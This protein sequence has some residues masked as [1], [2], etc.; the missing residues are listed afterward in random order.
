MERIAT[1]SQCLPPSDSCGRGDA[2]AKGHVKMGHTHFYGSEKKAKAMAEKLPI[3]GEALKET[4][5]ATTSEC[6]LDS[7]YPKAPFDSASSKIAHSCNSTSQ[8]ACEEDFLEVRRAS[9]YRSTKLQK[10]FQLGV[11]NEPK[12][13]KKVD[14]RQNLKRDKLL[15]GANCTQ[16]R[17]VA[18]KKADD[19]FV[20]NESSKKF[21]N[22][23]GKEKKE[24]EGV[25]RNMSNLPH[26]LQSRERGETFQERALHFGVLDWSLLEK[27]N[28]KQGGKGRRRSFHSPSGSDT[29]SSFSTLE[30]SS[31]SCRSEASS[32]TRRERSPP[33][34]LNS[35]LNSA[36]VST[37]NPQCLSQSSSP[38]KGQ[39]RHV[40]YVDGLRNDS[41]Q[42]STSYLQMKAD[43]ESLPNEYL[44]FKFL[45]GNIVVN[46]GSELG[47]IQSKSDPLE[48]EIPF[49]DLKA[50]EYFYPTGTGVDT[51]KED[52]RS[53]TEQAGFELPK[54]SWVSG[55]ATPRFFSAGEC[56][57]ETCSEVSQH[58]EDALPVSA[59]I[60]STH[61]GSLED[62][63]NIQFVDCY[64]ELPNSNS[65]GGDMQAV[66]PALL[67]ECSS[68]VHGSSLQKA[69][70][71]QN[72]LYLDDNRS[73]PQDNTQKRL[74]SKS[75]T[76]TVHDK[77]TSNLGIALHARSG[78]NDVLSH[79]S[80]PA[81]HNEPVQDNK[82]VDISLKPALACSDQL[83]PKTMVRE[84]LPVDVSRIHK[85]RRAKSFSVSGDQ[86][87]AINHVESTFMT[88]KSSSVRA[89]A[90]SCHSGISKDGCKVCRKV[91]VSP[92]R[93]WIDP[94]VK[95]RERHQM[96]LSFYSHLEGPVLHHEHDSNGV[97]NSR[98]GTR[99]DK[100]LKKSLTWGFP[101]AIH[102]ASRS[103][104][105]RSTSS[106]NQTFFASEIDNSSK[107]FLPVSRSTCISPEPRPE[108][109]SE[110]LSDS[111]S[112]TNNAC[113][114]TLAPPAHPPILQ[115]LLHFVYKN[116]LPYFTFSLNESEKVLA[117]KTWKID[118]FDRKD[119]DWMYTFHSGQNN[120]KKRNKTGWVNWGRKD[121]HT[122]DIVGK[123]KVSC[124]LCTKLNNSGSMEHL[125][126]T[127]FVLFDA[128]KGH[129]KESPAMQTDFAEK[130][131]IGPPQLAQSRDSSS[132]AHFSDSFSTT[133]S[134]S[135][136]S[137]TTEILIPR[138][139]ASP[140]HV[141]RKR[142]MHVLKYPFRQS[143]SES[144][145]S[146][147]MRSRSAGRNTSCQGTWSDS[148]IVDSDTCLSRGFWPH[149]ELAALVI[150]VPLEQR[151]SVK[152][153]PEEDTVSNETG[154]WG[155]RFL[156]KNGDDSRSESPVN[157]PPP[158]SVENSHSDYCKDSGTIGEYSNTSAL[159]SIQSSGRPSFANYSLE[160][161][162]TSLGCE[163]QRHSSVTVIVPSG[164]HSLPTTD[165]SGPSSL[166]ERWRSGGRCDCGGWDLG[167]TL[168]LLDNRN[169][170]RSGL[171]EG[172]NNAETYHASD[173]F[174]RGAKQSTPALSLAVVHDGLYLL[175][176]EAQLSA[177]QAFSIGV[178]M[179][180]S[181]EPFMSTKES[182]LQELCSSSLCAP[183][184]KQVR[185]LSQE[186]ST[187]QDDILTNVY[188]NHK[189]FSV[190][191]PPHSPFG[192]V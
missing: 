119:F 48:N 95:S 167:C 146:S 125:V 170:N 6:N 11:P 29:S 150:R 13:E 49:S 18:Q 182:N 2:R 75:L 188:R 22:H 147:P 47:E 123:M 113:S 45:E 175:S 100:S 128:N 72:H 162:D 34:S 166:I 76:F 104:S 131:P 99:A 58:S 51:E 158:E 134:T 7:S 133:S 25:I 4:P 106:E 103:S 108:L 43:S 157:L 50:P 67:D 114:G 132:N 181:R 88:S 120:N 184:A 116:G 152:G 94:I 161:L 42:M 105:A 160:S 17:E 46:Q 56:S 135:V 171:M 83:Q 176:F 28:R 74:L 66:D 117:A 148:D 144:R 155:L 19:Y 107:Q 112:E 78:S 149:L 180:H 16:K 151:E 59:V 139:L 32:F 38:A 64:D 61:A 121:N 177:L 92:L 89:D 86:D 122:P 118:K 191:D 130:S 12:G 141:D 186:I 90:C 91:S 136:P 30:S 138:S 54:E 84:G 187:P 63:V 68:P 37:C 110:K 102:K 8:K 69:S 70:C 178:A 154:G 179:L 15:E 185:T 20:P 9:I 97:L 31:F 53:K 24:T 73:V 5:I 41:E 124:S 98:T 192:R 26:Y 145:Q 127:E 62:E 93:R 36:S 174:I 27:W 65:V 163:T 60:G 23:M 79:R 39:Q 142:E 40:I 35:Y 82:A 77:L 159:N 153:G 156:E 57:P 87:P 183:L 172:Y 14:S 85:N 169:P 137:Y 165:S 115:G 80:Q 1:G 3:K 109:I 129:V 168:T 111:I 126:E 33:N 164:M 52:C 81:T 71:N 10:K 140:I 143:F 44:D 190:P 96:G 101:G 189:V 173:L 21:P 55:L